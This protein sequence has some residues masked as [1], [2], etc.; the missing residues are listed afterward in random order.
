[1]ASK[2][3]GDSPCSPRAGDSWHSFSYEAAVL[4]QWQLELEERDKNLMA[5]NATAVERDN[6]LMAL[7]ATLVA[8]EIEVVE[9][10]SLVMEHERDL[11]A[12]SSALTA[13]HNCLVEKSARVEEDE[14]DMWEWCATLRAGHDEL[15]EQ[16]TKTFVHQ[17][18][19]MAWDAMLAARDAE[20]VKKEALVDEKEVTLVALE[21]TLTA[22]AAGLGH[23]E[24]L[25]GDEVPE[26][27]GSACSEK[28]AEPNHP[29]QVCHNDLVWAALQA[30]MDREAAAIS[31]RVDAELAAASGQSLASSS[32][33]ELA[34]IADPDPWNR[35]VKL[36]MEVER[37]ALARLMEVYCERRALA[38]PLV[39]GLR[40]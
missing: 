17:H 25:S 9:K 22:L 26:D 27:N 18:D 14:D 36:A 32:W 39:G 21:T 35:R 7:N 1:M 30:A 13:R 11:K 2:A 24:P 3:D 34:T 37:R 15:V 31:D 28:S 33:T 40:V 6:N 5:L 16:E 12:W 20:L 4:L 38:Q 29:A 19:L 10:E 23:M 8:R